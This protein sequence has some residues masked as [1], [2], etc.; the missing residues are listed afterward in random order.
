MAE[1]MNVIM[2]LERVLV[3]P[4]KPKSSAPPLPK[5]WAEV[6]AMRRKK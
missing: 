3:K 1:A 4:E 6:M 5:T 2:K